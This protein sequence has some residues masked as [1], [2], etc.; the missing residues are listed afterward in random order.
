MKYYSPKKNLIYVIKRKLT[1]MPGWEWAY[2][3]VVVN[4]RLLPY[5]KAYIELWKRDKV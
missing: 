1:D 4:K 3:F 2:H 5:K